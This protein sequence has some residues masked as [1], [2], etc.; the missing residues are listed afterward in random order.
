MFMCMYGPLLAG[1]DIR[2]LYIQP[3]DRHLDV[4]GGP[5]GAAGGRLVGSA[6]DLQ[7]LIVTK[8]PRTTPARMVALWGAPLACRLLRG[9]EEAVA[10]SVVDYRCCASSATANTSEPSDRQHTR[11]NGCGCCA[12]AL[13][14]SFGSDQFQT[15][16]VETG[17]PAPVLR[18]LITGD[19]FCVTQA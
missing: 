16:L 10:G 1:P 11:C 4:H 18:A 15:E 12:L 19:S 14:L 9:G 8:Q 17:P 13:E 3:P 2:L 7:A 6:C 5:G